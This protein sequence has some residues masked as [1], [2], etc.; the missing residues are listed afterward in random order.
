MIL[1]VITKTQVNWEEVTG[2]NFQSSRM[3]KIRCLILVFPSY[4]K[5]NI[6]KQ[7]QLEESHNYWFEI[8]WILFNISAE[9]FVSGSLQNLSFYSSWKTSLC[10]CSET[11]LRESCDLDATIILSIFFPLQVKGIFFFPFV[12]VGARVFLHNFYKMNELFI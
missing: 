1:E 8:S 11:I 4:L 7:K 12:E 5:K 2:F 6:Y 10:H 9:L 3:R